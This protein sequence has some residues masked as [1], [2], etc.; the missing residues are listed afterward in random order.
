MR[1]SNGNALF[2]ILIAVA[3]F[4]AL[5]YAITNSGRGGGNVSKEQAEIIAAQIID[6]TALMM[7]TIQRLEL[8]GGYD[9]I[10]F[11]N[12]DPNASGTC[13]NGAT[14]IT[15]CNTVGL[16]NSADG[17]SSDPVDAGLNLKWWITNVQ[18]SVNG[19]QIGTTDP[20]LEI[21][22][23]DIGKDVCNAINRR[24]YNDSTPMDGNLIGSVAANASWGRTDN[25][26]TKSGG[27]TAFN[28]Q[29]G[30][31]GADFE[32]KQGCVMWAGSPDYYAYYDYILEK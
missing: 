13:Y 17:I 26:W 14:V 6:H 9:Q 10:L 29:P 18:A 15:P 25:F 23:D 31:D 1:S 7:Q 24:L 19:Q 28:P 22:I 5:S 11:D 27:F 21:W 4:A 20:D 8:I 12:S 30:S 32:K 3:L 16:Y 2:L